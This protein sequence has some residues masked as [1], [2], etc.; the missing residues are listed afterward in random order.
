MGSRGEEHYV[1][2][3]CDFFAENDAL[4]RHV[5]GDI[6]AFLAENPSIPVYDYDKATPTVDFYA[7]LEQDTLQKRRPATAT[8][9]W[10]KH[11]HLV[12]FRVMDMRANA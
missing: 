6:Y 7:V 12:E 1:P 8:N 10:Q 3:Y 4:G 9:P 5:I 2:I 11:W